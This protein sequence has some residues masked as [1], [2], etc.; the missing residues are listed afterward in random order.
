MVHM[1]TMNLLKE[2]KFICTAQISASELQTWV[3]KPAKYQCSRNSYL[4]V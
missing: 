4:H 2:T 3:S 1:G